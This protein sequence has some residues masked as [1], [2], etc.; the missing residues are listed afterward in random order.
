MLEPKVGEEAPAWAD[1]WEVAQSG[2]SEHKRGR[3][4]AIW[5]QH[6]SPRGVKEGVHICVEGWG[7]DS[8]QRFVHLG[9][10]IKQ[11]NILRLMGPGFSL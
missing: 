11:V 5:K 2:V 3:E 1:R 7:W 8:T 9:A 4:A 10:M 6:W